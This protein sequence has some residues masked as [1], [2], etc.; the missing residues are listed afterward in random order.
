LPYEFEGVQGAGR[1]Q[2]DDAFFDWGE[3]GKIDRNW[4]PGTHKNELPLENEVVDFGGG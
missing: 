3:P 1:L 2:L 4:F